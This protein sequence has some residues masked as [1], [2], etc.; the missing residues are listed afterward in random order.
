MLRVRGSEGEWVKE[1]S[2]LKVENIDGYDMGTDGAA[3]ML[4]WTMLP[5]PWRDSVFSGACHLIMSQRCM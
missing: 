4:K 3:H 2:Q 1:T 5:P